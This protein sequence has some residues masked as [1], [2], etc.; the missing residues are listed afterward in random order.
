MITANPG[1]VLAEAWQRQ[2][3]RLQPG[4][5]GDLVVIASPTEGA[6][7]PDPF[8]TILRATETDVRLVVVNGKP[9]Y[10]TEQLMPQASAAQTS[11]IPINGEMRHLTLT[12][13]EGNDEPWSYKDVLKRLEEVRDD[14]KMAIESA[15]RL[16]FAAIRTG[17]PPPLRLALDMPTG[18]VP[19]GGLPKELS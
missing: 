15:R 5:L 11:R 18:R 4:A 16:A 2:T 13:F 3:G 6:S 10:G 1:D 14:P 12:R 19:V 8:K 17:I 7:R 9:L